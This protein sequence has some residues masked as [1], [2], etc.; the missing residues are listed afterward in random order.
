MSIGRSRWLARKHNDLPALTVPVCP[1][2]PIGVPDFANLANR[3]GHACCLLPA[4]K[5]F[6]G[7][8]TPLN[9]STRNEAPGPG[10][11]NTEEH[12]HADDSLLHVHPRPD[13]EP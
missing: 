10:P 6:G 5:R 12:A 3:A 8:R 13:D 2:E 4:A 1:N 7:C 11:S 9:H